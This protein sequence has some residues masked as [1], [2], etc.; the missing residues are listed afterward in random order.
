M[1]EYQ[2]VR[3]TGKDGGETGKWSF[4][5]DMWWNLNILRGVLKKSGAV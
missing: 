1:P 3:S 5:L 2:W 4:D